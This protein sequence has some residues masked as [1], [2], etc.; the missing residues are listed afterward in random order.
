MIGAGKLSVSIWSPFLEQIGDFLRMGK[1]PHPPRNAGGAK[2]TTP[3]ASVPDTHHNVFSDDKDKPKKSRA[4][5]ENA[6]VK[7]GPS[8]GGPD[9]Q[10]PRPDARK[11]IGGASWTGKLPQT[12]LSE[13]CQKQKWAKP[14]FSMRQVPGG[15]FQSS[16][17]L[18]SKNPKTQ[19]VTTLPP[20]LLPPAKRDLATEPTA[21]E[22]RHFAATWALFRISSMKNMHM[23]LPPKYRDLWKGEFEQIKQEDIRAGN[24]WMYAPDPFAAKADREAAKVEADKKREAIQKE[25]AKAAKEP[26]FSFVASGDSGPKRA[27]SAKGWHH[28]LPM[29]IGDS[30]RSD[31]EEIVRR[32]A[33]WNP[34][35]LEMRE[36]QRSNIVRDLVNLGFRQSH[37]EEALQQCKDREEALE[38]LLVYCPEDDLPTW[39]FP[40]GYS[41][42]VTFASGNLVKEAALKRLAAAGYPMDDCERAYKEADGNENLA[43]AKLQ[44]RL[45]YHESDS[46]DAVGEA[47]DQWHEE[48]LTLESIFADRYSSNSKSDCA[49]SLKLSNPSDISL[50][51]KFIKPPGPYPHV[52]PIMSLI[53]SELPAYIRLSA[54]RKALEW[55]GE[56]LL[57]DPM[58]FSLVDWVEN[59]LPDTIKTPGKLRD[60]ELASAADFNHTSESNSKDLAGSRSNRNRTHRNNRGDADNNAIYEAWK[61]RQETHQQQKMLHARQSLPAWSAKDSITLSINKHQVT[62]VSGETG[63]GKSTQSV[64]FVLDDMIQNSKG[65]MA[66]ILCTQPRRISALGLADRVSS[67]RC[68]SVGDEV[69]YIIRG[70]SK[71]SEKTKIIFMTTGVLLRRLQSFDIS[72]SLSDVSHIFVDEVH[73]RN[74]DTDF[75]LALLRDALRTNK[76]LKVVLM[77]AT[78]DADAFINYF[79]GSEQ[80]GTINIP[81]RT[82]AVQDYFLD[83]V[84]HMTNF[85]SGR[86]PFDEDE[87]SQVNG[88]MDQ[89]SI[90]KTIQNLGM[91]INYDLIAA[92]VRHIDQSLGNKDGAILIFLPGTMEI[93]RCL[94]AMRA[95]PNVHTLPLHAS[96]MPAEQKLVFLPAPGRKRKVIAATNVAETSITIEDIVAVID[97]GRVKE[98]RYDSTNRVVRLEEVWAS[99]AACKQRR[100]RA[101]RVRAGTCYKLFTRNVEQEMAPRPVPEIRRVPLAQL[102]LSVKATDSS[103][104]VAGF[105]RQTL[106]P[107]DEGAVDIALDLLHQIGALEDGHLTALG[108]YLALI[109]ADLRCAKLLVFGSIFG[110]LESCLTIAAILAVRSPFV[111][112]KDKREEAQAA[113]ASFSRDTGDMLVD[114]A[115]FDEWLDRSSS[116]NRRE[117]QSWCSSMFLSSQTLRDISSTRS[118]LLSSLKDAGIVPV[119]YRTPATSSQASLQMSSFNKNNANN[120]LLRAL[121][122]GALNPQKARIEFPSKKF[123]AS[124]SG[125][126][127]LDPEARTIKYFDRPHQ[128]LSSA[129]SIS[130]RTTPDTSSTTSSRVFIHPSSVLF[131]TQAFPST[132][133]FLSYFTKMSTSKLFIR[134]L[135][136]FNL[137]T[138]LLFGSDIKLVPE[139]GGLLADGGWIKVKGWAR[140]GVLIS[141]LRTLLDDVLRR[142]VDDPLREMTADDQKVVD[143]VRRCIEFNGMDR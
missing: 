45:Y 7:A 64:Q 52:L 53:S 72:G 29:E 105:L 89:L 68:S 141:R 102:C 16:V 88:M 13:H 12:L 24:E 4:K 20:F 106:T 112:P 101:G 27:A 117:T 75:L 59:A 94:G 121:I 30:L 17:T 78:L 62:I 21:L 140:I 65:A 81:G 76:H 110:C 48:L 132:S 134:D 32:K 111:S 11:I 143:L 137:Y 5:Q 108:R 120:T 41:A 50:Q 61:S 71:I 34:Y 122:A 92:T 126:V 138:L 97:T 118:Q 103:R 125:A 116:G 26:K 115:A 133:S 51:V 22:A 90:G 42:G 33:I 114:Q 15:G 99:Q 119:Q 40:D 56:S 57:G 6:A 73:E 39:A 2:K 25:K 104:D 79:G 60:V 85:Q 23:M 86:Y 107:P 28:A 113:R 130:D 83:D 9:Q 55:A 43:A 14:E 109:P 44:E 100:G 127:E 91:G 19:E 1:K 142:R 38:W 82:F 69:G 35:Q 36:S 8:T 70:D 58:L 96:L 136:P 77:S 49:V 46:V 47:A 87:A 124:I 10:P 123:A 66:N 93:D 139:Q 31:I 131:T 80:V 98:T 129:A 95:M 63:S 54:T 135:T 74:L 128:P 18:S 84:I 3:T 37:A 67:E